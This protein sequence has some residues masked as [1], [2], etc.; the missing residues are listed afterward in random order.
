[1]RKLYILTVLLAV[2]L[3][4]A[5]KEKDLRIDTPNGQLVLTPLTDNAVR[6]RIVGGTAVP[7]LEELVYTEDVKAPKFKTSVRDGLH[8]L[9]LKGMSAVYDMS[10]DVLSFYNA[11]GELILKESSRSIAESSVQDVPCLSVSQSFASPEDEVILGTGQFQDGY[12]NIKGLTRRL[13]QVNTQISVPFVLSNKGYGLLWNNYGLTDFNPAD[14]VCQLEAAGSEGGSVMVNATGTSGNRRERRSFGNFTGTMSV[15][16]DGQY[17]ILLDVGQSMARK[18]YVAIDDVVCIDAN[19]TWL[20]PTASAIV[21]LKAGEHKVEVRG[22]MGDHPVLN[23]RRVDATTTFS[24][25]VA[26]ALDYTVFAGGADEVMRSYRRLTGEVPQMQDWM[27]GYIHCRERYNTQD[28][29]I[30]NMKGFQENDIPLSVIVQDWQWWGKY[31]WNAMRFDEDR[32]PDPAAL[33]AELHDNDVRLMLSVWSKVDRPSVLGRQLESRDYYIKGTDW[34]DFFKPE[35]RNYYLQNFLDSLVRFN[36]DAWWFDATEPE[37]DDLRG[38]RVGDESLPGEFYRN[39]YPLMVN[40]TMYGGLKN[41]ADGNEPVILTRSAFAG[42]QKYGIVTWSGDVGNDFRTLHNQI[43]G[44]LGQMAAGLPWWTF[45]AGGFFRPSDQYSDEA[46]Q[47]RMIRWVQV[48]T[49][50]PFMRVHGYMSQTEPWRYSAQTQRIMTDFIKLRYKLQPYILEC[51]EKVSEEGYTMMR[52]LLFDFPNDRKALEQDVEYM[53]GPDYLVCPVLEAG[54]ESVHVYLPEN[55][56][57]WTDFW[58]GTH[59]EGGTEAD[60]PVTLETIPVFRRM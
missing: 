3:P 24:S 19:N 41:A 58:N 54:A 4:C 28:E 32:Y 10:A 37:N 21:S 40:R 56:G 39:V 17:A 5:G 43:V 47:E 42:M 33:T 51:A 16:S 52:P 55:K 60:I 31:G 30:S 7:Q 11:S 18:H 46:Y 15:P 29:I 1:M 26:T 6:V 45:D 38:R 34:I 59:Y 25:P 12:L 57:G 13:T 9:K 35:A 2:M 14:R 36:I 50:L 49:F 8:T 27:F 53:F 44:G 20:P 23:W 48:A 22:S